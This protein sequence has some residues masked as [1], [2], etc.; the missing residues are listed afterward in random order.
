MIVVI[1]NLITFSLVFIKSFLRRN[2]LS[3]KSDDS[4]VVATK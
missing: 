3:N 4:V 2:Q 1:G